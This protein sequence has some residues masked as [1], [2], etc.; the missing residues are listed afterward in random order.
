MAKVINA[1][2]VILGIFCGY[3]QATKDL[4]PIL[5][6]WSVSVTWDAPIKYQNV[7]FCSLVDPESKK[8]YFWIGR[9]LRQAVM[10]SAALGRTVSPYEEGRFMARH[11]F[12]HV[13]QFNEVGM[14]ANL[15][16]CRKPYV[17]QFREV[18]ANAFAFGRPVGTAEEVKAAMLQGGV[19][20]PWRRCLPSSA[21]KYIKSPLSTVAWIEGFIMCLYWQYKHRWKSWYLFS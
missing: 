11:E 4:G 8:V 5:R 12:R 18:D 10:D 7:P 1:V 20:L 19:K 2:K 3:Y 9:L 14:E 21:D 6:D 16:D 15:V 13:W 17:L